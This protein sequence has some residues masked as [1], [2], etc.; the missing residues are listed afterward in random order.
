M[1][2]KVDVICFDFYTNDLE[3]LQKKECIYKGFEILQLC[4]FILLRKSEFLKQMKMPNYFNF[5]EVS[6]ITHSHVCLAHSVYD[7]HNC[8]NFPVITLS[9]ELTHLLITH[10]I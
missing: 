5:L 4:E 9:S 10:F 7:C 2:S 8:W 6:T 1:N 3:S